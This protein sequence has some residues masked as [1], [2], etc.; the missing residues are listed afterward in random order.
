MLGKLTATCK[1]I[2]ETLILPHIQKP[3]QKT[4]PRCKCKNYKIS[5][6]IKSSWHQIWQWFLRHDTKSTGNKTKISWTTAKF[7]TVHQKTIRLKRQSKEQEKISAYL[8]SNQYSEYIKLLQLNI[9]TNWFF[10]WAKD[11]NKYFSK[12]DRQL[13][14]RNNV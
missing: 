2:N 12:E 11:L 13:S 10:K 5:R 4:N 8:I 6:R 3:T 7:K 14:T 1:R 9:K